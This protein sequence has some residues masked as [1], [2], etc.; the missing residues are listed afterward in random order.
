[1]TRAR[2]TVLVFML[3]SAAACGGESADTTAAAEEPVTTAAET[4][5]VTTTTTAPATTSTTETTTT[6][7]VAPMPT[8]EEVA[9]LFSGYWNALGSEDWEAAR[10]MST[11]YAA[12]YATFSE[13]LDGISPNPP[14]VI[15]ESTQTGPVVDVGEGKTGTEMRIVLEPSDG[16][17]AGFT[18]QNPVVV[19]EDGQFL[20]DYW[21]DGLGNDEWPASLAQRLQSVEPYEPTNC[22]SGTN[23]AY[24]QQYGPTADTLSLVAIG[25]VCVPDSDVTPNPERFRLF[26]GGLAGGNDPVF[27]STVLWENGPEAIPAGE[28]RQFVAVYQYPLES[29]TEVLGL[30]YG[31][32]PASGSPFEFSTEVPAFPIEP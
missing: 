20:L 30:N 9:A 26:L 31:F 25:Y 15:V 8:A 21:G 1:M 28:A 17:S 24:L 16:S 5:L 7:A 19:S 6:T 29:V 12:D 22:S 11:G 14:Q 27:A 13:Q 4:T 18:V 2:F 32:V 10:S 23:W 3:V